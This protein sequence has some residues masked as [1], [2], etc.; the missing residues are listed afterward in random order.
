M[1]SFRPSEDRERPALGAR[2]GPGRSPSH[3]QLLRVRKGALAALAAV[4]AAALLSACNV[5][6]TAPESTV[7]LPTPTTPA[8]TPVPGGPGTQTVVNPQAF[9][10]Q[11]PGRAIPARNVSGNS[12]PPSTGATHNYY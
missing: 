6:W 12:G 8:L 11:S 2:Q 4:A 10:T 3:P 7:K 5:P 1:S 9:H